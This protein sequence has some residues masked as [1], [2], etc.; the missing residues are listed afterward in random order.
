MS[1][2][3]VPSLAAES[4]HV[5]LTDL[6]QRIR[7]GLLPVLREEGWT[8]VDVAPGSY[9]IPGPHLPPEKRP[10]TFCTAAE[11]SVAEPVVS[12]ASAPVI[13]D[14]EI[15]ALSEERP[16]ARD[17]SSEALSEDE[18]MLVEDE[19]VDD[20]GSLDLGDWRAAR[21]KN[22]RLRRPPPRQQH[23]EHH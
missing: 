22:S 9:S 2:W 19:S 23:H 12:E 10:A 6:L 8:F 5:P 14:L 18:E 4:W 15:A 21:A 20:V 3:V 1:C 17:D 11:C 7:D 13:S 16:S